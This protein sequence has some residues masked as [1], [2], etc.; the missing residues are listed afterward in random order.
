M[1]RLLAVWVVLGLGVAWAGYRFL[2]T[3]RQEPP[4][5]TARAYVAAWGRGDWAA[6]RR[7]VEKPPPGFG[8][9][10]AR[11]MNDLQAAGATVEGGVVTDAGETASAP[12]TVTVEVRGLGPWAYRTGIALVKRERSWRVAWTSKT[13][14]P[15]LGPGRHFTVTKSWP[16]RA[17]ILAHDGTPIT[18]VQEVLVIGLEPRRIQDRAQV[19]QALSAELGTDG[20]KLSAQID[21]SRPEWF[22]PVKELR[23]DEFNR[24]WPKLQPIPGIVVQRKQGRTGP[25]E[26]FGAHVLG[27]TGPVT[28]ELLQQLGEPYAAGDAV[29]LSGIEREFER[30]LAGR[31]S[32]EIRTVDEQGRNAKVIQRFP[33]TPPEPVRTALDIRVQTAAER[34][35]DGVAQPAAI[36]AIDAASGEVRAIVSRPLTGFNRSSGGKYPPGSTFKIVTAAALLGGGLTPAD[37]VACPGEVTVGGKKFRNVEGAALGDIPFSEAFAKSCNTAFAQLAG[38]LD[39]AK[40]QAAAETFGFGSSYSLP[41][42]AVGGSF[43]APRDRAEKAAAAI[44]QARVE[45]SPLHMASVAAAVAAGT[46][47][48]PRLVLDAPAEGG[49]PPPSERPLDPAVTETLRSLMYLV[50]TDGTG[51]AAAEGVRP[52]AV[53]GKTGSAEFGRGTPPPTH[54]WFL[55]F[56]GGLAFAVFVEGGG[57]GGRVAAP[58][59]A[60]FLAAL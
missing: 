48:P 37:P 3:S 5:E 45:A 14:H 24:V 26:G 16:E 60:R 17:P 57:L 47:R 13:L 55:G 39:A 10:H 23:G 1:T 30:R 38:T 50:V 54:A 11:M 22:L 32:G 46:W 2:E 25:A 43:P 18:A 56:R 6:M 19:L 59:A 52:P 12:V 36:V 49:E 28:A 4:Q 41:P 15:D 34:A 20:A 44:G 27:R 53:A 9:V 31:P 42:K 29:G 58:I 7:L 33:G 8:D 21:R 51:T 40:L 35:L